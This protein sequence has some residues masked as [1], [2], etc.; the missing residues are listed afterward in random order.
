MSARA[1]RIASIA[2]VSVAA[3]AF[4]WLSLTALVTSR[5]PGPAI[6]IAETDDLQEDLVVMGQSVVIVGHVR[7]GVLA[8][9][10]DVN[11]SGSVDGDVASIGG[12]VIQTEG[13][14]ISGDVLIMGGHYTHASDLCRGEGTETV[15]FAGTGQALRD[16][17]AN[18]AR[19]LLVPTIDR[20]YLGWR[21]A[22]ALSSFL[23]AIVLVAVAP[24]QIG[25]ASERL[26]ADSLRIAAI[27]LVGTLAV[28]LFVGL[29]L[30]ALPAPL[31]A[32][33]SALLLF[34][35]V[36]VQLFGR[37]V[38]Y[39]MVGRWLQR[40]LLGETSRSQTVALLLGVLAFAFVGSLPIV[41]A[42]LVFGTFIV[43]VGI[44]LTLPGS[45]AGA[46]S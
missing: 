12:S 42:L 18:P 19:K 8:L 46:K 36:V 9:G 11:V 34:A 41:G 39:F 35:L 23:L 17:F 16:F 32:G 7:G 5:E 13:S 3:A 33:L 44:L 29:A 24:K 38:A 15:V 27:G 21:I 28:V 40:R 4:A 22:A 30:V 26:A 14:H 31:S 1:I 45:A 25:L 10:G 37:V 6:V 2:L 20:S 43:S